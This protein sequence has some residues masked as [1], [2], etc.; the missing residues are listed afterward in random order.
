MFF[1]CEDEMVRLFRVTGTLGHRPVL[2]LVNRSGERG[3]FALDELFTEEEAAGFEKLLQSRNL[4]FRIEEIPR[5][6]QPEELTSW[7]LVGR[8]FEL[9]EQGADHLSFRV[10]GC[11]EA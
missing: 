10:V 4:E 8:L 5:P 3:S 9:E 11:V 2:W 7:N 1:V 6:V